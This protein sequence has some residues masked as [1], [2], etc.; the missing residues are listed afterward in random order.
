MDPPLTATTIEPRPHTHERVLDPVLP[1]P[2]VG[3][4]PQAAT[5]DIVTTDSPD[6]TS[7]DGL[8]SL[9][10]SAPND[11]P[12]NRLVPKSIPEIIEEDY[13]LASS[14]IHR[15][16]IEETPNTDADVLAKVLVNV[17]KSAVL[18]IHLLR[19]SEP[20][21]PPSTSPLNIPT[22][23]ESFFRLPP[24]RDMQPEEQTVPLQELSESDNLSAIHANLLRPRMQASPTNA[25]IEPIAAIPSENLAARQMFINVYSHQDL[26]AQLEMLST[27]NPTWAA[28]ILLSRTDISAIRTTEGLAVTRCQQVTANF[29]F[30][31]HE[32][33]ETC[34]ML[35]PVLVEAELWFLVPGTKDLIESSPTAPCPHPLS[36]EGTSAQRPL[37]PIPRISSASRTFLFNPPTTFFRTVDATDV[38]PSA[39]IALLHQNQQEITTRLSKRGI[40]SNAW[41]TMKNTTLRAR[42]SPMDLYDNTTTKLT[43]GVETSKRSVLRMV[44]WIVIPILIVALLLGSCVIYIKFYFLHRAATTASSAVFGAARSFIPRPRDSRGNRAANAAR[45]P[46]LNG[47][48][49][50]EPLFVP[51]IYT[52]VDSIN[53]IRSPLPYIKL[54]IRKTEVTALI[55]SG[56]SISYMKLS[57][58]HEISPSTSFAPRNTTTTAA[59]GTAIHLVAVIKLPVTTGRYPITHQSWVATCANASRIRLHPPPQQDRPATFVRSPQ[60]RHRHWRRTP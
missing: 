41:M 3:K 31:N 34:Y 56:A 11:T 23:N 1:L 59:N 32:I 17:G 46:S 12:D 5:V 50:E 47:I 15:V 29:T 27:T 39:H 6:T 2:L 33:N 52:I 21:E 49:M 8:A 42:Q 14:P 51:R 37:P 57:T 10:T 20:T 7:N 13:D 55:D 36:T 43:E 35:T 28:R 22:L 54:T 48:E 58:L 38:S 30:N 60:T 4:R 44:L 18:P 19:S 25:L 9:T 45:V 16:P 26:K 40:L 24:Y 53:S